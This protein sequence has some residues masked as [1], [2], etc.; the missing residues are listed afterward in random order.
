M[1]LYFRQIHIIAIGF[2]LHG[3]NVAGTE[4]YQDV[5]RN[6]LYMEGATSKVLLNGLDEIK[7]GEDEENGEDRSRLEDVADAGVRKT[8]SKT[9]ETRASGEKSG[10]KS[11]ASAIVPGVS[12]PVI[13]RHQQYKAAPQTGPLMVGPDRPDYRT[14]FTKVALQHRS[15]TGLGCSF[16]NLPF[17]R[18]SRFTPTIIGEYDSQYSHKYGKL[19][20]GSGNSFGAAHQTQT[21]LNLL[22]TRQPHD[23]YILAWDDLWTCASALVA[24]FYCACEFT[25]DWRAS[26][27][28]L[29]SKHDEY[30][31]ATDAE[32]E[33]ISFQ[34]QARYYEKVDGCHW[35]RISSR[36]LMQTF[37]G[38]KIDPIV[39]L[40]FRFCE[41]RQTWKDNLR[42]GGM[43]NRTI[44]GT[45]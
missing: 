28:I 12:Q 39:D 7:E 35:F 5:E 43:G 24:R 20:P 23:R 40:F 29:P 1:A 31:T 25:L 17:L 37:V 16:V 2:F 6:C 32:I 38:K 11:M 34:T 18:M 27:R 19:S 22:L 10:I 9:H 3:K 36:Y 41:K 44:L 30:K 42:G 21:M 45:E 13:Q 14:Y 8:R 33:Q 15:I 4:I 26:P